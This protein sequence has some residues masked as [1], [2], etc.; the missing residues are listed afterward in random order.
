MMDVLLDGVL[1]LCLPLLAWLVL[2]TESLSQAVVLF[3][4]FGLLSALGWARLEAPDIALVEAAVGTGLT[5]ALLMHTLS[6]TEETPPDIRARGRRRPWAL[7][8]VAA[9]TL[10]LGWAVLALPADSPGLGPLVEARREE[11]GVKHPVTA[12][13][14]NFRGYDTLLEIAVLLVAALGARAVNPRSERPTPDAGDDPLTGELFRM[15][16]PALLLVA[17]Y[18]V[19]V[20]D[21]GPGGAFQAGAILAGGGVVALLTMRMGP[22]RMSSWQVRWALLTGPMLFIGVAVAPLF[23]G[24]SL[25]E[26]PRLY[27]GTLIFV[28]ELA[29]TVTIAMVLLMFFP[30]TRPP[31]AGAEGEP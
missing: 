22:P 25:L 21:H 10:M 19:W 24:R 3:V 27:A 8:A 30:G 28:V 9:S 7:L 23:T 16:I 13:L 6:W 14:L 31:R 17:G 18:L 29:L 12:V 2:R 5:G 4:A 20:G 11:S 15:M 1:A 26:L